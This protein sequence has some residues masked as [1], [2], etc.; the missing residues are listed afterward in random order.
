LERVEGNEWED[1]VVLTLVSAGELENRLKELSEEGRAF[2]YRR[3]LVQ[4]RIGL[5]RADLLR[6]SGVALS[7]GVIAWVL[8]GRG[9]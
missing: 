7:T 8:L 6:G 4:G 9:G 1:E 5:I 3:R 2:S